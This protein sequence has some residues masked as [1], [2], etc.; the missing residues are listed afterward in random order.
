MPNIV[1]Y[2]ETDKPDWIQVQFD[3]GSSTHVQ[4]PAGSYRKEVDDVATKLGFKQAV[5]GLAGVA[6][7]MPLTAPVSPAEAL[8]LQVSAADRAILSGQAPPPPVGT[9]MQTMEQ[10]LGAPVGAITPMPA[11]LDEA[12]KHP[13]VPMRGSPP[14]SLVTDAERASLSAD[15]ADLAGIRRGLGEVSKAGGVAPAAA[16]A[17]RPTYGRAP[18][19][20]MSGASVA[21]TGLTA[22]DQATVN[23][24]RG[25]AIE[26]ADAARRAKLEADTERVNAQFQSLTDDAKTKLAEQAVLKQQEDAFTQKISDNHR[27]LET[28]LARKVDPGEAFKGDAQYYAF[29][30]GFGDALQNF[31]AALA[32]RGP[33]ANPGET[34][35]RIIN[36]NV[37]M[38]T[39]QKE[40][41]F[42]KGKL[43]GDELSAER[44]TIRAKQLTVAKQL[45]DNM[46]AKERNQDRRAEL[47]AASEFITAERSDAIAKAAEASAR[48]EQRQEQFAPLKLGDGKANNPTIEAL[49]LLGV[50]PD[51]YD[52]GMN[53]KI[54][55][56]EGAPTY[57]QAVQSLA[58]IQADV[59]LLD[60]LAKENGG[61]VPQKGLLKVPDALVPLLAKIGIKSGMQAEQAN[62]LIQEYTMKRAR[63][64]GASITTGDIESA[65]KET[66][67][68]T[69]ALRRFMT[70]QYNQT[71]NA[72]R[73]GLDTKFVGRGQ[74]VLDLSR[75]RFQQIQGMPMPEGVEDFE[76]QSAEHTGAGQGKDDNDAPSAPADP[77]RTLKTKG[78]SRALQ[79]SVDTDD[80][81][82]PGN[83]L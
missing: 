46:L 79:D 59:S 58:E 69:E 21:T 24:T 28:D 11:G 41:D 37:Q 77:V 19:M 42:R 31:G 51:D 38:Q 55:T 26:D 5:S 15:P 43:T 72:I 61:K 27:R 50:T 70:R 80:D 13:M 71:N 82:N 35:N 74:E 2:S 57:N 25:T 23:A 16:P 9:P 6:P 47:T 34:I 22:E 44:D 12:S 49:K 60:A 3:D 7:P 53:A 73:Q 14:G 64:Y 4:D 20:G 78:L 1:G 45:T 63:S 10:P 68:S 66:G 75:R 83:P 56:Q 30:A 62:Q 33:V 76:V 54:G 65:Q 36:R 67:A 18:P 39:E 29:M 81:Q 52:K 48:H 8:P 17:P 40:A 32:G